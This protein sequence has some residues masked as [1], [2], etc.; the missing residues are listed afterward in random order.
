SSSTLL[1]SLDDQIERVLIRVVETAAERIGQ[2]S[3]RQRAVEVGPLLVDEDALQVSNT[4]ELF[5][6]DQPSRW[7][8]RPTLLIVPPHSKRVEILEGET[9][10]I[11]TRMAGR[12]ERIGSVR[13]ENLAE[14]GLMVPD[15]GR[16]L[17]ELRHGARWRWRWSSEDVV[18]HEETALDR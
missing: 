13:L 18:E 10:R 6:G 1:E 8:D 4:V 7:V 17:L 12:A 3:L 16:R 5:P 11:E 9:E 14:S 2:Q 15:R